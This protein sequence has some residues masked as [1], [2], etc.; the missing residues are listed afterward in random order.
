MTSHE[1]EPGLNAHKT[2]HFLPPHLHIWIY[3]NSIAI[4]N[5]FISNTF[6]DDLNQSWPSVHAVLWRA[7]K[8][9]KFKDEAMLELSE[10]YQKRFGPLRYLVAGFLKFLSL[11]KYDYEVEYLPA[12]KED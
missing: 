10:K 3:A 12:S 1:L 9:I 8:H 11:L 6:P 4:A 2:H 5:D 7:K